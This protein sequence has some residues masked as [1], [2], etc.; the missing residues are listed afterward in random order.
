[1]QNNGRNKAPGRWITMV[2][3][4]AVAVAIWVAVSHTPGATQSAPTANATADPNFSVS[5]N[6]LTQPAAQSTVTQPVSVPSA[7]ALRTRGS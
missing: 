1:M 7:A 3:S 5:D 4:A 6:F 2:G